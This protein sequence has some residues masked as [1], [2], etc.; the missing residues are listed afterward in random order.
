ML[1]LSSTQK[2]LLQLVLVI[3]ILLLSLL[4]I[5]IRVFKPYEQSCSYTV[6]TYE[7]NGCFAN[8]PDYEIKENCKPCG[9]LEPCRNGFDLNAQIDILH[10]LCDNGKLQNAAEFALLFNIHPELS[11][12]ICDRIP[13]KIEY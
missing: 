5:V 11:V 4:S 7:Y 2:L 9:G 12:H 6:K 10:C 3:S 13:D 1:T 8:Y